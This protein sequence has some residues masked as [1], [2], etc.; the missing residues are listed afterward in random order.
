MGAS[1]RFLR[2]VNL[3]VVFDN[4]ETMIPFGAGKYFPV[5]HVEVDPDG[6]NNIH[7]LDGSV[8]KGV[9]SEVFE[10]AGRGRVVPVEAA[11]PSAENFEIA[12]PEE[13]VKPVT[14]EGTMLSESEEQDADQPQ[15]FTTPF[16]RYS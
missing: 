16:G 4:N 8:I 13:E 1:V 12:D 9:A 2:N 5:T 15:P 3:K 11:P 14:L 7:M 10:F 6:F